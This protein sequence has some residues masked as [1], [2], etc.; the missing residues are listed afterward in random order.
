MDK[1]TYTPAEVAEKLGRS[2]RTIYRHLRSGRLT[3]ARPGGGEWTITRSDLVE[4]SEAKRDTVFGESKGGIG[5]DQD[6]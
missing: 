5:S 3:A 2:R 4:Y 6:R 1:R